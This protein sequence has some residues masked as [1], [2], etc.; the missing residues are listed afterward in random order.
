MSQLQQDVLGPEPL[1]LESET[2]LGPLLIGIIAGGCM[3]CT[4]CTFCCFSMLRGNGKSQITKA[5]STDSLEFHGPAATEPSPDHKAVTVCVA[6][7]RRTREDRQDPPPEQEV[8][9]ESTV[10][11]SLPSPLPSPSAASYQSRITPLASPCSIASVSSQ[12]RLPLPSPSAMSVSSISAVLQSPH[13]M[14]SY[15]EMFADGMELQSPS[16]RGPNSPKKRGSTQP[17]L[18]ALSEHQSVGEPQNEQTALFAA[19]SSPSNYLR[20][21]SP[22]RRR[23]APAAPLPAVAEMEKQ[24]GDL[25]VPSQAQSDN[26]ESAGTEKRQRKKKGPRP[27]TLELDRYLPEDETPAR[28]QEDVEV[29]YATSPSKSPSKRNGSHAFA[30]AWLRDETCGSGAGTPSHAQRPVLSSQSDSI[31]NRPHRAQNLLVTE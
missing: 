30:P 5:K 22:S 17:A 12:P 29:N 18:P 19:L 31:F 14:P 1:L 9:D 25:P 6:A 4:C 16:R 26:E 11:C 27:P 28:E 3:A 7:G 23:A 21:A 13:S 8:P 2:A 24:T 10:A 20:S 15:P